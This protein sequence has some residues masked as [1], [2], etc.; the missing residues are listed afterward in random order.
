MLF[1]LDMPLTSGCIALEN[2]QKCDPSFVFVV[3]LKQLKVQLF[4]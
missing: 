2:I 4:Y 1:S 3:V